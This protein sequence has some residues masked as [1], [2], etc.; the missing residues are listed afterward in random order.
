M[1]PGPRYLSVQPLKGIA[2]ESYFIRSSL[3]S[4]FVL[5]FQFYFIAASR[6]QKL[7]Y[8]FS[9]TG[10]LC[11]LQNLR[12]DYKCLCGLDHFLVISTTHHSAVV[13]MRRN[14]TVQ[15]IPHKAGECE[16]SCITQRTLYLFSPSFVRMTTNDFKIVRQ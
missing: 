8:R 15:Y 5:N 9:E 13:N 11:R 3:E 2:E 16:T 14:K 10:L 1:F 12:G 6:S 4:A 7:L